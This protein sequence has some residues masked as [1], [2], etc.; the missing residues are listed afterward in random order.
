VLDSSFHFSFS[1]VLNTLLIVTIIMSLERKIDQVLQ[2]SDLKEQVNKFCSLAD[3][4]IVSGS[5]AAF[6]GLK[7]LSDKL[8]SDEV[9]QQV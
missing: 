5:S 6:Q 3:E 2:V 4:I 1:G 7:T 9:Q 8:L